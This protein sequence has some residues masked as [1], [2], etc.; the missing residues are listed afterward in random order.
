MTQSTPSAL[1]EAHYPSRWEADVLLRDGRAAHLRPITP[2]DADRLAD[3]QRSLSPES[4]YF[5]YFASRGELTAAELIHLTTV[6]H[7]KRVA[8]VLTVGQQ[9]I[10]VGRYESTAPTTA[11]IAITVRDNHQARGVGSILLEHLAAAGRER[12]LRTFTGSVLPENERM[13]DVFTDAGFEARAHLVDGI[14]ELQMD[15]TPTEE[16]VRVMEAREH[17]AEAVS[18]R[19]LLAPESVVLVGASIRE[20]SFG[21]TLLSNLRDAGFA[22][23]LSVVHPTA[24]QIAGIQAYQSVRE[25]P[26]SIDLA[27]VAVPADAVLDVVRQ[28]SEKQARA[29]VVISSG[30]AEDGPE[31]RQRQEQLVQVARGRGMRVVG[32][33]CLGLINTDPAVA[34][35]ASL[36]PSMPPAGRIGFFSQSGA[37]GIA[38]L[39]TV[40][41]R[42]LGV[43]TFI[44]AGNRADVSGNDVLQYWEEDPA[45]DVVLLY[46][47]SIGNPRKFTR[48][49]RRITRNKPIVAMKTG[50]S[51][52]ARPLGHEVR[53]SSLPPAALDALFAQSGV[54]QTETLNHL[55]DV[56]QVL[57]LQPLPSGRAVRVIGNSD[58]LGVLAADA[59]QQ[60]G[61]TAEG[62]TTSLGASAT[63]EN[64]DQALTQ[65]LA[66]PT[67]D[68]ILAIFVPP[69]S[70]AGEGAVEAIARAGASGTKPVVATV[71]GVGPDGGGLL[72][73]LIRRDDAGVPQPGSVPAYFSVEEAVRA[74]AGAADYADYR[75]S[76]VGEMP[77][78]DD[79]RPSE[80]RRRL[81][82]LVATSTADGDLTAEQTSAV[83]GCYGI[84]VWP[85]VRVSTEDVAAET[86]EQLGF[87]VGLRVDDPE[88]G[89]RA[90][91]GGQRLNLE[92]P[93][94]VRTAFRRLTN[95]FGH[96][97]ESL[98][99]QRMTPPGVVCTLRAHDDTLFGP[100]MSFGL[101]GVATELMGD[102]GYAIPPLT[103]VDAARLVRTP[104]TAAMLTGDTGAPPVDLPALED[105]VL[106]LS[107]LID[108]HPQIAEVTLEPIVVSPNSMAVL[109]ARMRLTPKERR[110]E[111][112]ARRLAD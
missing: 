74:L 42:G 54:I 75:R 62:A 107:A 69:L 21:H 35:N 72:E 47:E 38:L 7:D 23:R 45:T 68:A 82:D 101:A 18:I 93:A 32:P 78:F 56:A 103:D 100:V 17:R 4:I 44:G 96:R 12:G 13:L 108:D 105:L 67:A 48:L 87:P 66:D 28:C 63:S 59:A 58:A 112:L 31:G 71:V 8:L 94:A 84:E 16:S 106:R 111:A 11:E 79:I 65:A 99:L 53:R 49:A 90:D 26:D 5:R 39:E 33:N 83:L 98:V 1:G 70:A 50:G 20:G 95:R 25:V 41:R 76:P 14:V 30:F 46:L 77:E 85:S 3:F 51:L 102:R 29:V 88:I 86:A 97:V 27:V 60:R 10:G 73:S 52:Q 34:L 36:A 15:L 43:S 81:A 109:A 110:G 64:F 24:P 92:S 91:L 6:D 40:R 80:A 37:L 57:T 2:E 9:I 89:A 104:R 61:L 22:G 19:R 55:F